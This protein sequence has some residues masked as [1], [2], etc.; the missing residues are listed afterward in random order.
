MSASR[1]HRNISEVAV[2]REARFAKTPRAGPC[3]Y[4]VLCKRTIRNM[5]VFI[6]RYQTIY[7]VAID[8]FFDAPEALS[9]ISIASVN[10]IS[11]GSSFYFISRDRRGVNEVTTDPPASSQNSAEKKLC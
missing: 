1:T 7:S 9:L 4:Q 2:S 8:S 3:N 6:G 5:P 11:I 10:A